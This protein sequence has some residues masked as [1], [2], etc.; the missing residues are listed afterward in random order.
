MPLILILILCVITIIFWDVAKEYKEAIGSLATFVTAWA[1]YEAR[2]SAKAAMKATQLTADSLLEMKKASFKEWYGILLEQHDKLLEDVNNTLLND[3]EFNTKLSINSI[4]SIYYYV[5]KQPIYIKYVNHI[6]L[7]LNYLDKEFY[8]LSAAEDETRIYIAQ[9]RSSINHKVSLLIAIFGLNIE[10]NKTYDLS[11]LS[12]LLNKYNFFESE[13]FFDEAISKVHYLEMYV[14]EIFNKEYRKAVEFYVDEMIR[15]REN[16]NIDLNTRMQRATF[17]ILWSYNNPCKQHLQQKFNELPLHMRNN[18]NLNMEKAD[19]EVCKFNSDLTSYVGWSLNIAGKRQRVIKNEKEISRL[20]KIYYKYNLNSRSADILL[21]DGRTNI[22]SENIEGSLSKYALYKA[23]F[24]L[25]S[26]PRKDE[27]I[28]AI[29]NE[30][31]KMV[32]KFKAELNSF[33]FN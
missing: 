11:R 27:E 1:A 19:A 18:I 24:D 7:I 28:H 26:N 20:I 12:N 17:A 23:Y 8:L 25:N 2:N 4:K 6:I 22:F 13:L 21:T 5:T 9:L 16:F 32:D 33:G 30:V 31:E 29:V 14:T 3:K 10:N 15:D